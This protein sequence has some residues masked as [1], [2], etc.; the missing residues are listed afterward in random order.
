MVEALKSVDHPVTFV[1]S[2]IL[3]SLIP[4]N[5]LPQLFKPGPELASSQVGMENGDGVNDQPGVLG[6]VGSEVGQGHPILRLEP[7][8]RS[9][10]EPAGAVTLGVDREDEGVKALIGVG[11]L[12]EQL[13]VGVLDGPS[14]VSDLLLRPG[15][16]SR[17]QESPGV[18]EPRLVA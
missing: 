2:T 9:G 15:R 11:Q 14:P 17:K 5:P 18:M 12:T 13:I 16:I 6:V 7:G 8:E 1:L 3:D 4:T 10:G